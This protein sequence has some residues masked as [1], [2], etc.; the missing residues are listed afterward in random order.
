MFGDIPGTDKEYDRARWQIDVVCTMNHFLAQSLNRKY[1]KVCDIPDLPTLPHLRTVEDME[2]PYHA[3]Y[4][5]LI[6]LGDLGQGKHVKAEQAF[7]A[8]I[9]L[10]LGNN[11]V[12][13]GVLHRS[14]AETLTIWHY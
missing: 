12:S 6:G 9:R 8:A 5:F 13:L 10:P 7:R 11:L 14:C 3:C 2:A 4:T 1:D